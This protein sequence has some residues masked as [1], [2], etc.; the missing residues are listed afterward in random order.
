VVGAGGICARPE[1]G[2]V[3]PPTTPFGPTGRVFTK[4]EVGSVDHPL[5]RE[6][7]A[8][9]DHVMQVSSPPSPQHG[10]SPDL[11]TPTAENPEA[12]DLDDLDD[13]D[14]PDDLTMAS[15][16]PG[17]PNPG[18]DATATRTR[19]TGVVARRQHASGETEDEDFRRASAG[20]GR[21]GPTT[22]DFATEVRQRANLGGSAL[23]SSARSFLEPRLG[24]GLDRVRVHA[25]EQTDT[26]A[27]RIGARAFTVGQDI[28]FARGEFRPLARSGMHLLA[29]E[30]AHTLQSRALVHSEYARQRPFADNMLRR[31]GNTKFTFE[32]EAAEVSA[33]TYNEYG[34]ISRGPGLLAEFIRG[35]QKIPRFDG[36]RVFGR[37][38]ED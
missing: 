3:M 34:K 28:F 8:I 5:E 29:H 19:S 2:S 27:R 33:T 14:N 26:L 18:S 11:A 30:V 15:S 25:D 6:A 20:G 35:G 12:T 32:S 22:D 7:D 37:G 10:R 17:D 9:A 36:G 4:L 16:A 21:G 31:M 13:L 1:P 24:V 38:V 23:P